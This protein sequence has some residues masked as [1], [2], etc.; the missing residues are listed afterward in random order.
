METRP[1]AP[2]AGPGWRHAA[3]ALGAALSLIGVHWLAV[4]PERAEPAAQPAAGR[5]AAAAARAASA[6]ETTLP[7][8]AAQ[9][10][11]TREPAAPEAPAPVEN[12]P[13][14]EAAVPADAPPAVAVSL[15]ARPWAHI[16]IDGK[17]V[18]VTPLAD[19]PLAPGLHRFRARFAD[20]RV[21][22]RTTRVDAYRNRVVFP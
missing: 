4:V 15:N 1:R 19:V 3:A 2:R 5:T 12:A 7:S 16:E 11:A 8:V 14:A 6:P 18:G 10:A 21:I 17:E 20:G 13:E 22:E 9:P